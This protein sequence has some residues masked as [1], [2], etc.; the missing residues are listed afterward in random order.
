MKKYTFSPLAA[1]SLTTAKIRQ[2]TRIVNFRQ[3]FDYKILTY[4]K[5]NLYYMSITKSHFSL[6]LF[7][8]YQF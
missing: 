5:I 8:Y 6:N 2:N 1:S 4:S 7:Y 3:P